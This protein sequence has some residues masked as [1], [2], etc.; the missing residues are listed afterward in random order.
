[1]CSFTHLPHL[2][3][4]IPLV[5]NPHHAEPWDVL[6]CEGVSVQLVPHPGRL[7]GAGPDRDWLTAIGILGRVGRPRLGGMSIAYWEVSRAIAEAA[8]SDYDFSVLACLIRDLWGTKVAT[9][10]GGPQGD[11]NSCKQSLEY[12]K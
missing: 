6:L 7:K 4:K 9:P 11:C 10:L 5:D 1:M 2:R 8:S 12:G 3:H